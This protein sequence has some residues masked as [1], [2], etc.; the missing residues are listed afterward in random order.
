MR[1]AHG[2]DV[3]ALHQRHVALELFGGQRITGARVGVVMVDALELDRRFVEQKAL[4]VNAHSAKAHAHTH[5][6]VFFAVMKLQKQIIELRRFRCPKPHVVKGEEK[7]V[8]RRRTA[9]LFP[10]KRTAVIERGGQRFAGKVFAGKRAD[11]K[12]L[13]AVFALFRFDLDIPN[14]ARAAFGEINVAEDAVFAEHVLTF[15]IGAVAPFGY[16]GKQLVFAGLH[17]FVNGKLRRIVAALA[18]ADI[19]PVDIERQ[20][21]AHAEKGEH[22]VGG[23]FFDMKFFDINAA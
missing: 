13:P 3:E 14:A 23:R 10:Q 5:E 22:G 11:D 12:Q 17:H 16:N 7:A 18:V 20:R 2:V 15:K 6:F 19:L 4:A 21:R 8:L 1:G 9:A